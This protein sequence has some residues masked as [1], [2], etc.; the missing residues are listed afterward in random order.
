MIVSVIA[1]MGVNGVIGD[2]A[3]L[4]WHLPMDLKRFRDI[5]WG[6]PI[7]MGRRT[8]ELIGRPLPGRCNILLTHNPGYSAS[9]YQIVH[10]LKESLSAAHD[11][12]IQSGGEEAMVIGGGKVYAEFIH[13]CDKLYITI[14]GDRFTGTAR[15]PVE[16]LREPQWQVVDWSHFPPDAKNLY[17]HDF[18][19]L[20]KA[21]GGPAAEAPGAEGKKIPAAVLLEIMEAKQFLAGDRSGDDAHSRPAQASLTRPLGVPQ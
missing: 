21:S 16:R 18:Y 13:L 19:L 6:K 17:F 11:F 15:F 2:D 14:V 7:I 5:T 4:P 8:A 20:E 9:G 12:L 1:A 3:G 10:S